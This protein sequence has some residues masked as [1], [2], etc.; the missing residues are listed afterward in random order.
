MLI[1]MKFGG[2]S[3]GSAERIGQAAQ[4]AVD[5][6]NKGHQVVVVTSAMSKVTDSLIAAAR[7]AST[8][9]WDSRI[10]QELFDRHNIVADALVGADPPRHADVLD[11]LQ[12]AARPIRK[13]L[14]RSLDGS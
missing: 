6:A 1:V 7:Q 2:T 9:Q 13:A 3:V 10:R 12:T 8:G 4:L 5:T 11:A 14:L